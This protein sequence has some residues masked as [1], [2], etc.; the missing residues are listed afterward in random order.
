VAIKSTATA[1]KLTGFP[2]SFKTEIPQLHRELFPTLSDLITFIPVTGKFQII[3]GTQIFQEKD[4]NY[5]V[6][7]QIPIFHQILNI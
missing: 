4:L 5:L 6:K 7:S 1:E 2:V 3:S